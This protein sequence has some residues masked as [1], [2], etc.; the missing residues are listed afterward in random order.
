MTKT[1][2][3]SPNI[4]LVNSFL[5]INST[6]LIVVEI[7]L[8]MKNLQVSSS[9]INYLSTLLRMRKSISKIISKVVFST[10]KISL[11]KPSPIKL[12]FYL[13]VGQDHFED[14]EGRAINFLGPNIGF[15]YFKTQFD[16]IRGYSIDFTSQVDQ[17]PCVM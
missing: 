2:T 9:Y 12:I 11:K 13:E 6:R 16:C 14:V 10:K 1:S 3:F 15:S 5:L 8:V 7:S 17:S 4:I